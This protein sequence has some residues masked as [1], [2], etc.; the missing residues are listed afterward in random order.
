MIIM[1]G[2]AMHPAAVAAMSAR[3]A[4]RV[5]SRVIP[6]TSSPAAVAAAAVAMAEI[7]I[8]IGTE[9]IIVP[10]HRRRGHTVAQLWIIIVVHLVPMIIVRSPPIITAPRTLRPHRLLHMR[11]PRMAL[12]PVTLVTR[13]PAAL[14]I[15]PALDRTTSTAMIMDV[16]SR[17]HVTDQIAG[18]RCQAARATTAPPTGH[19]V[20]KPIASISID[21]PIDPA[22]TS[23]PP[24]VH[25]N[26]TDQLYHHHRQVRQPLDH[27]ITIWIVMDPDQEPVEATRNPPSLC[28][29]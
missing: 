15:T 10:L 25:T 3:T 1:N 8:A 2:I 22:A 13:H 21:L 6:S 5:R 17:H 24:I 26:R 4:P 16:Q 18:K 20:Q 11:S 23:H 27:R 9:I 14:E 7:G 19:R 29:T 12:A 28:R